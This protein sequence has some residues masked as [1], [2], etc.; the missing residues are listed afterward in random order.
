M[1]DEIRNCAS[2]KI[3]ELVAATHSYLTMAPNHAF[4]FYYDTEQAKK[5]KFMFIMQNPAIPTDWPKSIDFKTLTTFPNN[6]DFIKYSRD[7]LF[8]WLN[9]KNRPFLG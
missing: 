5:T 9:G 3:R 8:D 7:S 2:C 4:T 6:A 1:I